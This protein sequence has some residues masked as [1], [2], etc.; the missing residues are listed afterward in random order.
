VDTLLRGGSVY[1]P[2]D[3][4]ATA[5]LVSGDTVAWVGSDDAAAGHARLAEQVIDL[6]GALV[7]PAFVD[8][9]AHTTETGLALTGVDLSTATSLAEALRRIEDAGRRA[10][11][12]PILGHGW[13][14]R[15]W[16]EAR[17]PTAPS[18]TGR[19]TAGP[20]TSRGS[21]STRLS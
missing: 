14:E 9:H 10:R 4:F 11:G 5:M 15:H 3:P 18:S 16:P 2:A 6:D 1:S 8:A 19:R 13:D 12:R 20:S 17:P 21:T 7:T